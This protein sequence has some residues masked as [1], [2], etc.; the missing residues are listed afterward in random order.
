MKNDCE[1]IFALKSVLLSMHHSSL[2]IYGVHSF[3]VRMYGD[4]VLLVT[5]HRSQDL[6]SSDYGDQCHQLFSC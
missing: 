1:L 2:H 5:K 6:C 4:P 3:S